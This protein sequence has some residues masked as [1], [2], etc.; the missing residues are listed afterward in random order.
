[1]ISIGNN[2]KELSEIREQ[3]NIIHD[4]FQVSEIF[5]NEG[6]PK[7]WTNDTVEIIGLETNNRL[8][9]NKIKKIEN[10][11]SYQKSLVLMGLN[12]DYNLT[13]DNWSFGKNPINAST[14]IK[15]NRIGILNGS[16]VSIQILVFKL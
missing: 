3:N 5:F 10:D 15:T 6:S 9:W 8:D 14:I 13:I 1:M 2:S 11:I 12:Y 16:L 7:N 4:S